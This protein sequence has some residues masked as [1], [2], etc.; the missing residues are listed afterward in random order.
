MLECGTGRP[1]KYKNL[2]EDLANS[3]TSNFKH[4]NIN[5]SNFKY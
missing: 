2:K 1:F 3:E 5:P 4:Q